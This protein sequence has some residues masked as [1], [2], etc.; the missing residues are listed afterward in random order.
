MKC[1]LPNWNKNFESLLAALL[2]AGHIAAI[3]AIP[4]LRPAVQRGPPRGGGRGFDGG[5]RGYRVHPPNFVAQRDPARGGGFSGE[6]AA[7]SRPFSS[8]AIRP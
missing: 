6:V 8:S 3:G 4:C 5:S 2:F 7:T 1:P